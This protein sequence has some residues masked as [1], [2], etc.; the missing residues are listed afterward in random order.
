MNR[1]DAI[2][3]IIVAYNEVFYE[4]HT[5]KTLLQSIKFSFLE[6]YHILIY[7]NSDEIFWNVSFMDLSEKNHIVYF[8]DRKNSGLSTA[9]N[10]MAREAGSLNVKWIV[11]LDQDTFVPENAVEGYLKSIKD[12]NDI[13]LKV[14]I[15]YF[16]KNNIMSPSKF[17]FGRAKMLKEIIV[18]PQ[19]IKEFLFINSGLM[20]YLPFFEEVG[21][22]NE[23]IRV[24][25]A[26]HQFIEKVRKYVDKFEVL[27]LK[28]VQNFSHTE[29]NIDKAITRFKIYLNDFRNFKFEKLSRRLLYSLSVFLHTLKLTKIFKSTQFLKL[30]FTALTSK[31]K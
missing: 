27:P 14:P 17:I 30:Y 4:T 9:Y 26:D 10:F 6:N 25:F 29:K 1:K 24:D 5:Y 8:H 16:N 12:D 15:V 7:D 3:F 2:A 20:I 28:F 13:F 11:L 22:Y 21:G 23:K 31:V 18:G 19:S